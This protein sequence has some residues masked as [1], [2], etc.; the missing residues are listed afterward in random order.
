ME[1]EASFLDEIIVTGYGTQTRREVTASIVRDAADIERIAVASSIDAI[2]GQVAGV[3]IQS[4]GGRPGQSPVVRIRGRRS[5]SASNDP[6]YVVDGIPV[7]SSVA[8]G[9]IADI[10]PQDI[11]SMGNIERCCCDGY[12]WF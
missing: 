4:A 3:D 5:L 2:K 9:A 12:L 11:Q 7:T 1:E 10:A 6:L 8:G